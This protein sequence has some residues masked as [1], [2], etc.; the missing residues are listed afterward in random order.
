MTVAERFRASHPPGASDA[1]RG[2]PPARRFASLSAACIVA[3]VVVCGSLRLPPGAV[4][5]AVALQTVA[6]AVATAGIRVGHPHRCV[7]AANVVTLIRL[8]MV[9]VLA[10]FLFGGVDQPAAVIAIG[11]VGLGLDGLDGHLARRQ[12]LTSPFG[13]SFD[14]EVDSALALVLALLAASGPA[15]PIAVVLGLPR[16][17]FGAAAIVAPWLN[18]ELAARISRKVVCVLQLVAL[19]CLQVPFLPPTIALAIVAA[20]AVMLAWSFGTDVVALRRRRRDEP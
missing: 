17:L 15:G 20:T 19:L 16:Y 10:A 8:G 1:R 11:A 12:R 14:M 7:G 13:G 6:L 2:V 18:G 4:A 3:V 9:T 5:A